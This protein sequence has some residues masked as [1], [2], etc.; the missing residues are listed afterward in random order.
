MWYFAYGPNLNA[1]AVADWCRRHGHPSPPLTGGRPAVLDDRRLCFPT[2]NEDW[3]GGIADVI[4]DPGRSVMGVLFEVGQSDLDRLDGKVGRRVDGDGKEVGLYRRVE[5]TV[6]PLG[7]GDPVVA[8]TYEGVARGG[9][10]RAPHVP[11]VPPTRHY[12]G[13]LIRGAFTHGLSLAWISYLQSFRTQPGR[14]PQPRS[15]HEA[16]A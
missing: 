12:M 9:G 15:A 3:G 13:L 8:T 6:M 5:R 2:Y 11:H 10:G 7:G 4:Y 1:C 16:A 14:N